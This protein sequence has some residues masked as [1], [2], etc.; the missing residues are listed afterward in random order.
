MNRTRLKTFKT[1]MTLMTFRPFKT[2]MRLRRCLPVASLMTKERKRYSPFSIARFLA[3]RARLQMFRGAHSCSAAV[4]I[5]PAISDA[6][7]AKPK[8]ARIGYSGGAGTLN[9]GSLRRS[10]LAL[11]SAWLVYVQP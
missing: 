2:F 10:Y 7:C 1:L 5:L 9:A 6:F 4:L 3:P 8:R 11:A